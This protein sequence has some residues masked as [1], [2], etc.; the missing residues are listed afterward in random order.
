[1]DYR[2]YQRQFRTCQWNAILWTVRLWD[3]AVI[4]LLIEEAGGEYLCVRQNEQ[5]GVGTVYCAVFGKP[6]IVS[7][8]VKLL[9]FSVS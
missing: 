5:P 4:Q 8:I 9:K 7:S 3:I 1:M 2:P 6:K